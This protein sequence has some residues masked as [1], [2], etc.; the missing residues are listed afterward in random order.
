[1]TVKAED[2]A[3]LPDVASGLLAG[4]KKWFYIGVCGMALVAGC[5][6]GLWDTIRGRSDS[7]SPV[8]SVASESDVPSPTSPWLIAEQVKA[9]KA[10]YEATKAADAIEH[11]TSRD[12]RALLDQRTLADRSEL[13][14]R[15]SRLESNVDS[16]VTVTGELKGDVK[17]MLEILK[18]QPKKY[19]G[20]VIEIPHFGDK[21]AKL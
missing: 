12:H 7:P 11:K 20:A 3:Q 6:V 5:V 8:R 19:S 16:L 14:T 15:M 4:A 21:G 18:S 13:N 10:E 2:Q 1:V 9:L 17:Q